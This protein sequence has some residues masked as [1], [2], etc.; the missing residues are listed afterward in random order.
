MGCL[1]GTDAFASYSRGKK[2]TDRNTANCNTDERQKENKLAM[3]KYM[4]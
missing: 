3:L 1:Q 2:V 4:W